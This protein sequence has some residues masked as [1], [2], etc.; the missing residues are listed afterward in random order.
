MAW[1]RW[2]A[3]AL[4]LV[5]LLLAGRRLGGHLPVFVG[6][7]QA[8]GARGPLLFVGGYAAATVAM[9]PGSILTLAAG[10]VFGLL[11][12]TVY[13]FAGATAGAS[14]AFLVARHFARGL[15]ERRVEADARF[16]AIDAAVGRQG[17][18][19]VLLLR[20]SPIFPFN[21]LNYSLGLT[22]VRYLDYL[23]ASVG[24]LPG[25]LLY[26]YYGR[27]A[28][29]LAAVAGGGAIERGPAYWALLAIGLIATVVVTTL[30]TRIARRALRQEVPD[31]P[32]P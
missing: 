10:A 5:A 18:K 26:V 8:Q 7:V 1:L 14:L 6:W 20:L 12:G 31:G 11:R 19:I 15:V 29:E 28:G 13:A 23:L 9:A 17:F 4:A 30:V 21:L 25:T 27:V 3:V 24:M 2:L 22:R 16:R 32:A